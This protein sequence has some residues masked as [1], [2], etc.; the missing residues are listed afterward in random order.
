MDVMGSS[1]NDEKPNPAQSPSDKFAAT[2]AFSAA[3]L[4]IL[5]D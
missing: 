2:A 3:W 5:L 4:K 1:L